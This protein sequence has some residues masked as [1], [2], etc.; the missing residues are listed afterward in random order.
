MLFQS[1]LSSMLNCLMSLLVFLCF[2]LFSLC[3]SHIPVVKKVK[4]MNEKVYEL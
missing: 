3:V 4:V 2:I 1:S